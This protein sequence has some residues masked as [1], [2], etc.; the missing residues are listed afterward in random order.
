L[1]TEK[2]TQVREKTQ[3]IKNISD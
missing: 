3:Q 1:N 2:D